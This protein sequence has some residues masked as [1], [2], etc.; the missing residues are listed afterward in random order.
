MGQASKRKKSAKNQAGAA[1]RAL[2]AGRI[3]PGIAQIARD[4][5]VEIISK[6]RAPDRVIEIATS[7]FFLAQ[8]LTWRFE[9]QNPL[10]QPLACKESCD[11]CCHNLVEL[12]PP[13]ALLIGQHIS[14]HF[15]D[16]EKDRVLSR[17]AKNLAL[18]AGKTKAALAA[19]RQDLPCPL[20]HGRACSVYP[21][22]PL[23]CRAMH[24]LNRERCEAEL[25]SGSLAGSQYYTHRHVI[26]LSVSAGLLEG[27]RAVGCQV[28]T[29]SLD[30]ALHDFFTQSNPVERWLNGEAVF[31]S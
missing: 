28:K 10:P 11:A 18:A 27:C 4:N 5:V 8:H 7:A 21:V 25:R 3:N 1:H 13:E 2:P 20:L 16:A 24:G 17:V 29:L 6:G 15:P 14:Q 22:R 23:V 9:A 26:A 30:R 19:V 12:T 31:A